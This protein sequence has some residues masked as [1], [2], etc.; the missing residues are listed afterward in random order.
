VLSNS[1]AGTFK[2]A[3]ESFYRHFLRGRGIFLLALLKMPL[4]VFAGTFKNAIESFC[5]HFSRC[6]KKN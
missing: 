2:C 3:I 6:H 5:W 4:N 1:I